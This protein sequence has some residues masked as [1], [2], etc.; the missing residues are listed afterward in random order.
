MAKLN[1]SQ[2]KPAK[3][4]APA[5]KTVRKTGRPSKRTPEIVDEI[6]ER[7]GKGEPL[8]QITR[9]EH[10]PSWTAFYRWMD[11][12]P[13]LAARFARA[14]ELGEEAIAQEC[15][16]IADN[17]TNDWMASQTGDGAELYKMNGEHV[18]RSKLRIWTRMELLKKWNPRKWGEKVDVNHGGQEGNPIQT[19]T[20]VVIV[21]P[22]APAE[23]KVKPLEKGEE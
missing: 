19:T 15:M 21:P 14:R 20:K 22:K 10:M 17:A 8:R 12:D 2:A 18:Q 7:I 16:E 11:E 23:V 9:D 3:K 1:K 4:S 13:E 5:A 6:L